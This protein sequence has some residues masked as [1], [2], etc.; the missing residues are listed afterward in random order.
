MAG[1]FFF[2]ELRRRKV[3]QTA[4]IYGAVAWGVTEVLVTVVEQLFLPQWVSTLTVI[5]FV[6]GFPV[7]MFLAWTFDITAEGIRRTD[8]ATR[9]GKASIALSVVLVL[10]GTGGLY[11]LIRPTLELS[12]RSAAEPVILANSIAVLPFENAGKDPGDAYLSEGLSDALRDQLGRVVGLR[13]AARSSSRAAVDRQL[14]ALEVSERLQVAHIVEGSIRRQGGILRVSVQLI[15]GQSG[16]ETWSTAY[17]RRPQELLRVQQAIVEAVAASVLPGSVVDAT[18]PATWNPTANELMMVARS[19][20]HR[21]WAREDVDIEFLMKAIQLYREATAVDPESALAYSR[22]AGALVWLGD[23]ESAE[24]PINMALTINPNLSE[25]QHTL[26]LFRWAGGLLSEARVAWARAAQLNPNN[27]EALQDY[28][29][30]RWYQGHHEGVQEMLRRAVELDPLNLE[31]YGVLGSYLAIEDDP[32]EARALVQQVDELFE[33][34]AACRV[35]AQVLAYLGDVDRAIAWT[36]RARDLEPQENSHT[37]KLAEYFADI[38]DFA[39]AFHLDPGAI[40][41]LFKM[42][43]YEELIGR[44]EMLMIEY[45]EDLWLRTLLGISHN[46]LGDH[47]PALHVLLT[48]GLPNSVLDGWRT[49]AEWD[50]LIALINARYGAGSTGAAREMAEIVVDWAAEGPNYHWWGLSSLACAQA[51]LGQDDKVREL[52][53]RMQAHGNLPWDP[54]L[55]DSPCFD[56][57][58]DDPVYQATVRYFEERRAM[59]RERLPATLA[60]FGVSL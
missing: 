39:T 50:G 33:G 52:L 55:K 31:P 26:G 58:S 21:V 41:V 44:A 27:P 7:A 19:Y 56:R 5:L 53:E 22:L 35:I 34:A 40:G 51:V 49:Q 29:R 60:E 1:R 38:G 46:A 16:L 42:R 12:Q 20:E 36:I 54:I 45:P 23:L 15:E 4:A 6:V 47:E 2:S 59:L 17:E 18:E 30:S 13:V 11:F 8:I 48:T 3:V 43:R 57:F 9:K 37:A 10:V 32:D 28:A 14:D 25:V 24:A